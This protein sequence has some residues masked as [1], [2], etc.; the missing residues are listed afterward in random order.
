MSKA[1]Q[2]MKGEFSQPAN[3]LTIEAFARSLAGQMVSIKGSSK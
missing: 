1:D 2:G 3:D